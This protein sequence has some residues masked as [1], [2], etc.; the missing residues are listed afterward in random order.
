MAHW[1][2]LHD[3]WTLTGAGEEVAAT[4]PGCVHTDLLAAGRIPDPYLDRNEHELRWI[5]ETDW[6]YATTFDWQP[7]DESNVDLV[8]DGLDTIATIVLNG[9]EVGRTFNMHRSY[10]FAV[11]EHLREGKNDL[12]ITFA[13]AAKYASALEER[14]G[15][16]PRAG[17]PEPF[18]FIRKMACNFGWDW[19]P[20]LVTAGI[21]K[22][23][24]LHSWSVARFDEVRPLV[25][26]DGSTGR[27]EVLVR[28]HDDEERVPVRVTADIGDLTASLDMA[29][30][31]NEA[32]LVLEA[33]D[34]A[35]WWPHG[36]GDQQLY[37]LAVTLDSDDGEA[38]DSWTKRIGFRTVELDTSADELGSAFTIK[39]NGQPIFAKGA[40]WIPDDCF[41]TRVD[42]TRYRARLEQAKEAHLDLLRIWG[43]GIYEQDTFYDLCDELGILV[44]QDFLFACAA[45]PEVSPIVEEI[46]PEARENVVRLM[47]HPSLVLWN[48]N[49]ENIWGWFDWGWQSSIGDRGW[50]KTYY[51]ET[52]P[53]VVAEV[54]PTRPYWPGSPYSGTFDL[55]PNVDEHGCKHIWDVW[56][57]VDYTHYRDYVPRFVAEFGFQGPP[58]W[59]TLTRAVHDDPL[60][61]DS[62]G[63]LSHQ[64]AG[65]GNDKLDR[66][67][68]AHFTMPSNV[69]DWHWLTQLNQARA[70]T[71]GIEHFRSHHGR[72]MGTVVWQLNDCWPVTSWAAVDGD[73]RR[74]P[75]WYALR[76]VYAPRL[77]TFQPRKDGLTLVAVND[78]ASPWS[79]TVTIERR[80]FAGE[81]LARFEAQLEIAPRAT[82]EVQL[83]AESAAVAADSELLVA[84][85]D[86]ERAFWFFGE[87]KDLSYPPAEYDL[88][89]DGQSVRVTARTLLR[90][91][92][93]FADRL[94]PDAYADDLLVT[95]LPG[96][97]HTFTIHNAPKLSA[98]SLVKPVVRCVND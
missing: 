38:L 48:G 44:W 86:G 63:V 14:L 17:Y 37:D 94:A 8:C 97:S 66:G 25:T 55:Q 70:L 52:L 67:L 78:A 47:P 74:K 73:G 23:I 32:S 27:V 92:S 53:S 2:D 12:T 15:T 34:A 35:L 79:G 30:G 9:V 71:V 18:N 19:G 40:N 85:A 81:V 54:D 11:K 33:E 76:N 93:L 28:L 10:R 39:V 31:E 41:P 90:D 1:E 57:Q 46:V 84:S 26:V 21:W 80:S 95:L 65:G 24:R 51:L 68:A 88:E 29:A 60:A 82:Q 64:K 69:E 61:P 77:L 56:N 16:L 75:L 43:G 22:P 98:A 49:N 36:Y 13:S 72:C 5:G 89:V 62:P 50:G 7:D 3:G 91:L 83:P 42:E 45:Y 6:R 58:A 20:T 59:S 87:D 4:V 96:E